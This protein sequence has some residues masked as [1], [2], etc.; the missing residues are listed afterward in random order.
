ML[1]FQATLYDADGRSKSTFYSFSGVTEELKAFIND[2]SNMTLK[3]LQD[4]NLLCARL[5]TLKNFYPEKFTVLIKWEHPDTMHC[6]RI[7]L[8]RIALWSE[9]EDSKFN[10]Q[11]VITDCC[12]DPNY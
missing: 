5:Y 9:Q 10:K 2:V 1:L 4:D 6:P 3:V 8:L 12:R 11:P 7:T